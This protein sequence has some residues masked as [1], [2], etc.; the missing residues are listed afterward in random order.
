M[1]A[2][3]VLGVGRA[4]LHHDAT[5]W[6]AAYPQAWALTHYLWKVERPKFALYM[7]KMA[8]REDGATLNGT[9]RQQ[10]FEDI[11]G[12]ADELHKKFVEYI[13]G[14]QNRPSALDI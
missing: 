1:V 9:Q 13:F 3:S 14:L 7:Q 2:G 5:G 8:N 4:A 6:P 12:P 10:E 11:F